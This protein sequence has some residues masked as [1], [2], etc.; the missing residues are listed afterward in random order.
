MADE[1][2][3]AAGSTLHCIRWMTHPLTNQLIFFK[4]QKIANKKKK[5]VFCRIREELRQKN[6][7]AMLQ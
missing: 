3:S 2:G 1:S 6:G 5:R 7:L 4:I